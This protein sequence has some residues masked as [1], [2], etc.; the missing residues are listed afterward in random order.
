MECNEA[1]YAE[2]VLAYIVGNYRGP[3]YIQQYYNPDCYIRLN[4][5]QA[6]V[7]QRVNEVNGMAIEKYGF[8]AIPNVFGLMSEAALEA[9]GVLRI[10]RQPNLDLYG[11]G[12]LIG[13]VDTGIDYTHE[14]FRAAD[15][16]TRI[17]SIW[18]Q[19]IREG[20]GTLQLPYG[21]VYD[22]EEINAALAAENPRDI[23]PTR[24]EI[25]HGTFMA[26][27][28][29]GNENQAEEFSGVAPLAEIVMVK[30]KQANK[31]YRDYYGIPDDVPAYQ[32][33]DIMAGL[34]YLLNISYREN[35]SLVLCL[36]IGSNMGN[37]NGSSA[38]GAF[39]THYLSIAGLGFVVG[40]GNEGNAR[41]HHR[42]EK[43]NDVIDISVENGVK[44]FMAQLW[45]QT[46]GRLTLDVISP[47][48][49]VVPNIRAISGGR[50]QHHFVPEDT[51]L[52]IFFGVALESTREQ[53]VV[54]RFLSPKQGIWKVQP[55]FDYANPRFN[56]WLPIRQF[57][58][59]EVVFLNSEPDNTVTNPSTT[60]NVIGVS[61]YDVVEGSLY[62]QAG[63]GFTPFDDV[64]PEIV[65][66]GVNITGTYP[67]NRYGTMTGTS[68]SAAFT[69]GVTSLLMQH[70][71]N[72]GMNNN[73]FREVLI[74]GATPRGEP[75]PN[76]EWGYGT[77]NAYRSIIDY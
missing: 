57:L 55:H 5:L 51:T 8:S 59:N 11:Q 19:T 25:G 6:V 46:P 41:H 3:E 14:A 16:T 53:V 50:Y 39:M 49:E 27:V 68:V 54:M 74:R 20:T 21:Q 28:A 7:Y 62:L 61:A 73:A 31:S 70:Y 18:D 32:E 71:T 30:C 1:V 48:G 76:T 56:I 58:K 47:S 17:V 15:G 36:G 66:P 2:D 33:N 13:F 45:W 65:A 24:D 77:I 26:G 67:N 23:V 52:E 63:R 34:A 9:S 10:R 12:T 29:A 37:H 72:Q 43:Q 40:V 35:K 38:I 69:A 42:I 44:G 75:Y 60:P 4:S 22:R 64:K